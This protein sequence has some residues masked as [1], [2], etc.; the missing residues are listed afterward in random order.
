MPPNL[1]AMAAVGVWVIQNVR[2]RFAQVEPLLV[3]NIV[4]AGPKPKF[5]HDLM[6]LIS[7]YPHE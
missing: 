3:T 5:R 7:Q 6:A 2:L 4:V 1:S